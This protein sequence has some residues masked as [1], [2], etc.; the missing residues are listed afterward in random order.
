[1]IY[2]TRPLENNLICATFN[3]CIQLKPEQEQVVLQTS[4][5]HGNDSAGLAKGEIK[6]EMCGTSA[7]WTIRKSIRQ[8]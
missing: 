1:M 4:L 8:M 7:S 2:Y 6:S 3:S 5:G